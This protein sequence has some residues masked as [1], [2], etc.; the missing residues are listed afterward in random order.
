MEQEQRGGALFVQTVCNVNITNCHFSSNQAADDGGAIF[1]KIASNLIVSNSSFEENNAQDSGGSIAVIDSSVSIR[2]SQFLSESVSY[3]FGGSICLLNTGDIDIEHSQ[4]TKC[5]AK[6]GGTFSVMLASKMYIEDSSIVNSISNTSGG[7]LYIYQSGKVLGRYLSLV[8]CKSLTGGGIHVEHS[9]SL[10]MNRSLIN[11]SS[12]GSGNGGGISSVDSEI[13]LHNCSISENTGS[14]QGGALYV[15][16]GNIFMDYVSFYMNSAVSYGGALSTLSSNIAIH[17]SKG[18]NNY[19]EKPG[20][21]MYLNRSTLVCKHL[22]VDDIST[23]S[24]GIITMT[25]SHANINSL[26][27]VSDHN[28]CPIAARVRTYLEIQGYYGTNNI[29][30]PR[31]ETMVGH[32]CTDNDSSII[33][34]AILGT[35][36]Y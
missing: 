9:S 3:G 35:N 22:Q 34:N 26:Q 28:F 21:F 18:V 4:F 17:N 27:F 14:G 25:N 33:G 20:G 32:V 31:N 5:N 23:N 1:I 8:N 10:Y 13:K 29:L 6:K 36:F 15:E 12:A 2:S 30:A 11:G 7:A 19:A 24:S 16:G